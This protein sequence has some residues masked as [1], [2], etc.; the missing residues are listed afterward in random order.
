MFATNVMA[1]D[2]SFGILSWRAARVIAAAVSVVVGI[3]TGAAAIVMGV[4]VLLSC[5]GSTGPI[6]VS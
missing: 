4:A 3:V 1:K 2:S 5:P 6:A